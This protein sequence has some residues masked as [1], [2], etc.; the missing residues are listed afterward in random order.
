ML[1]CRKNRENQSSL[2]NNKYINYCSNL[3]MT[4]VILSFLFV[5]GIV[6]CLQEIKLLKIVDYSVLKIMSSLNID[7]KPSSYKF[8]S[9]SVVLMVGD[10][11]YEKYFNATSPLDTKELALIIK[12][13][14]SKGP[15]AIVLDFDISPD[16]DFKNLDTTFLPREI[17]TLLSAVQQNNT[18]VFLPFSFKAETKE[19]K[20]LKQEWFNYMCSQG[21]ILGTPAI[22]ENFGAALT[23]LSFPNHI[24]IL[25]SSG[26]NSS[27]CS[28]I[29]SEESIDAINTHM[30]KEL[31]KIS[32]EFSINFTGIQKRT[33]E[34]LT[35]E[36]LR[37]VDLKDKVVFLGG[38]YGYS[39][40]YLTPSSEVN[41]VEI[42]EAI[43]YTQSHKIEKA[44]IV[45]SSVVD[46]VNGFLFGI[47][48]SFLLRNRLRFFRGEHYELY[49]IINILVFILLGAWMVFS[50]KLS[51]YMFV[52]F[53]IWL[54]PIPIIFGMFLDAIFAS[55]SLVGTHSNKES[56]AKK[57]NNTSAK[58][59]SNVNNKSK[60]YFSIRLLFTIIGM[61][62]LTV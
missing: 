43:Y 12:N 25:A 48:L 20:K 13:I 29:L 56:E 36:Q 46:V 22:Q 52:H 59:A 47:L 38:S 33:L 32:H 44:D 4:Q 30:K 1:F 40:K 55:A 45:F 16:V 10:Y 28:H 6:F 61:H 14:A 42:L 62:S 57:G 9:D 18:K 5:N 54:N 11:Y 50:L 41:G 39:D 8:H 34:L 35:K 49:T 31:K 7:S 24:S 53:Y 17:D 2:W 3:T 27:I 26:E 19:N 37:D 21:I 51:A 15:S 23:Y 60:L 58:M